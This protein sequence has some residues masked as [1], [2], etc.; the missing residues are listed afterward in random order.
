[1]SEG[2]TAVA[3]LLLNS[4]ITLPRADCNA[5]S[6]ALR[7]IFFSDGD[8]FK[9]W[10]IPDA[11]KKRTTSKSLAWLRQRQP[12]DLLLRRRV[13]LRSFAS[14]G[15]FLTVPPPSTQSCD[16]SR[17]PAPRAHWRVA[18]RYPVAAAAF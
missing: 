7:A 17:P 8:H 6:K 3:A 13:A 9:S 16:A 4:V 11:P 2:V 12:K 15:V 5:V 14:G 1:M 18:S 10:N